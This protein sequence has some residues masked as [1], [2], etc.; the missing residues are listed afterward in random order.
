MSSLRSKIFR[1]ILENR[2]FLSGK[3]KKTKHFD[4]NTPIEEF[5]A[6]VNKSHK[7][8]GKLPKQISMLPKQVDNLYCEWIKHEEADKNKA[9]LYFHG[10][11]YV[12]GTCAAHRIHVSKVVKES[13][14]NAFVFEYRV[15]PENPYPA[16][17]ED[18]IKAYKHLLDQGMRTDNI[19][20][21]GDS[22]GGGLALATLNALQDKQISLPA[23]AVVLSPWTD[24]KCTGDSYKTKLEVEPF[25]PK[26]S[27]T[28]FSHYYVQ[29]QNYL[30]PFISPLYGELKGLPP[31]KIYVG[32]DEVLLDDSV[33]YADKAN[34]NGVEV[35]I[36]IGEKMFHCYPICAPIFPEATIALKEISEFIRQK[37]N[38]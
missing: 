32:E 6:Q 17:L 16:A 9:I 26:E 22:A 5:R 33:R 7:L 19:V 23:G 34:K 8:F 27:W 10:G 36:T 21:M 20:F 18:A 4:F 14:V 13:K 28:V 38:C 30:N 15:A 3:I 1:L 2:H 12:S 29:D 25:A 11:G 35:E 31:I 37:I 24:L